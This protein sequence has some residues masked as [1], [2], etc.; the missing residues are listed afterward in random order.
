M[1]FSSQSVKLMKPYQWGEQPKI[2]PN[3]IKLNTNENPYPPHPSLS[4]TLAN[5]ATATL[6]LYPDPLC[7]ELRQSAAKHFKLTPDMITAGNG[8]D[9]L[10][11]LIFKVF[12]NRQD[13][14]LFTEYTYSH[15]K[16]YSKAFGV[17]YNTMPM[18]DL[19]VDLSLLNKI[20]CKVFFLTNPNAPTGIFLNPNEIEAYLKS[21]GGKL[22][23]ID[24][25]YADF[26]VKSCLPLIKKYNNILVL[27][28]FS[29]SFSL[30]GIRLGFA[31][32]NQALI[33]DLNK[34]KDP[35]N[36]SALTQKI[37]VEVFKHIA[38]YQKN[39]EKNK[40]NS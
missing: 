32:G 14:A 22:F 5:F 12:F 2:T 28:S 35:Y 18:K 39:I 7:R 29:K 37:G 26:S 38:Y 25:A 20:R 21:H 8:S 27:R 13:N 33:N 30:G 3:L 10:I 16:T 24:E 9:E 4:K 19:R 34:V 1:Q 31:L 40:R 6:R 17:I 36:V 11:A 15:Y 23:V